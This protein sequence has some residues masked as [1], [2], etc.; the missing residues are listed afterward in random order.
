MNSNQ[1]LGIELKQTLLPSLS[2]SR[3]QNSPNSPHLCS[4][5]FISSCSV[6]FPR[7]QHHADAWHSSCGWTDMCCTHKDPKAPGNHLKKEIISSHFKV[8]I[9]D[10]S[11]R[12]FIKYAMGIS[13][14]L[15]LLVFVC[16]FQGIQSPTC[17]LHCGLWLGLV[18]HSRATSAFG[19]NVAGHG[20]RI[21]WEQAEYYSWLL[22]FL[23]MNFMLRS[24]SLSHVSVA[25]IFHWSTWT[26]LY[27]K[28]HWLPPHTAPSIGTVFTSEVL[29][30][31]LYI[32][33]CHVFICRPHLPI[34]LQSFGHEGPFLS[35]TLSH[36][37][38]GDPHNIKILEVGR[39]LK[40]LLYY[41]EKIPS[42]WNVC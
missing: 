5:A 1:V 11:F 28:A 23:S 15:C 42:N 12:Y 32:I 16:G 33:Q 31:S 9:L 41:I 14:T 35:Y 7:Y 10:H 34:G 6:Q 25:T 36:W 38:L 8:A 27:F 21:T 37:Y 18:W 26:F 3:L 22:P 2:F 29:N 4:S 40:F 24:A 20:G 19:S 30:L 13:A 17:G 39:K